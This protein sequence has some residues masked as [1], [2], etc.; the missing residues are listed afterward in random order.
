MPWRELDTAQWAKRG[1]QMFF[2]LTTT[3]PT[4]PPASADPAIPSLVTPNK[5]PEVL[6]LDGTR[7]EVLDVDDP[8]AWLMQQLTVR[9]CPIKADAVVF[10]D[11]GV[12]L[13]YIKPNAPTDVVLSLCDATHRRLAAIEGAFPT[14]FV[15]KT[16]GKPRAA[17]ALTT[18]GAALAAEYNAFAQR[19][20]TVF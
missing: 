9:P 6:W 4:T 20:L 7:A 10:T 15:S 11:R 13:Y 14:F 17:V 1:I 5:P 12:H 3:H 16:T 18:A 2:T 19:N 8:P